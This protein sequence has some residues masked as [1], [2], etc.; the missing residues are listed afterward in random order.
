[1]AI[2]ARV[3]AI[4]ASIDS[5]IGQ[6]RGQFSSAKESAAADVAGVRAQ[7]SSASDGAIAQ[8]TSSEQQNKA[9]LMSGFGEAQNNVDPINSSL[10]QALDAAWSQRVQEI[11]DAGEAQ[12]QA[13]LL[14]RDSLQGGWQGGDGIVKDK[15]DARR[16]TASDVAAKYAA[17][18]R[19]KASLAAAELDGGRSQ[20]ASLVQDLLSPISG[21]LAS[22]QD[23]SESGIVNMAEQARQ[24]I[25]SQRSTALSNVESI[26]QNSL[27][28][29]QS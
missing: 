4:N 11:K 29:Y 13:V 2:N 7:I 20:I 14:K 21:E 8:V 6:V 26:E 25:E 18:I 16:K 15:N 10:V 12:A 22:Q 9:T 17:E 28:T 3:S 24:G 5:A 19:E 27:S 1:M 23:Q